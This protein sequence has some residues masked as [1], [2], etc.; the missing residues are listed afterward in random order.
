MAETRALIVFTVFTSVAITPG[1]GKGKG[2]PITGYEGPEG[3]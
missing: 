1:R 2:H 3:E